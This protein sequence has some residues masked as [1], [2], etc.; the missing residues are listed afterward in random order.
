MLRF[1]LRFISYDK[2]KSIGVILG[3]IISVFLIGQQTGI[4]LFLTGAM[5]SLVDNSGDDLWVVDNRTTDVNALGKIDIRIGHQLESFPGVKKAYPLIIAAGSA[6]FKDGKSVP[7]QLVGS[8]PPHFIGG[9]WKIID[10]NITDLLEDGAISVDY[11]ER[12]NLNNA[13]V[14]SVFEINGSRVWVAVQTKGARGFGATYVFTTISRARALAKIPR[15]K[16]SAYLIDLQESADPLKVRDRINAHL[17]GVRAWTKKEFSRSTVSTILSTSGIAFSIGTLIIFA[18]V[19]GMIIIGL[20]MYSAAVDRIKDYGTLKAIGA[21]NGYIRN[22]ILSQ[23]L[24][25]SL[26]G[27]SVAIV[28]IHGFRQAIANNGILFNYSLAIK[29]SFF[30]ITLLI[31]LGGAFF[32]MHRIAKL[33]PASVFRT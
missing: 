6:K 11:F 2:P 22:L 21:D 20:T 18:A 23:A 3:I 5:S 24:F 19:S 31:S 33:E 29:I 16:V 32:A 1:A 13:K 7:V 9:P 15:T 14:G 4:F 10:G 28:L 17:F 26:I 27:Y 25:F 12:E 8:Q 30:I